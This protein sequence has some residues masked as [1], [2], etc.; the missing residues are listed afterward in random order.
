MQILAFV[1]YYPPH[2]G[3]LESY[4]HQVYASLAKAHGVTVITCHLDNAPM[5]AVLDGV[6]VVRVPCWHLLRKTF[7][8]PK[9]SQLLRLTLRQF[10][11][12][13]PD[14]IHTHTRF[15]PLS[16]I[17]AHLARRLQR[18]YVHVE[19]GSAH[20]SHANPFIRWV[21]RLFDYCFGRSVIRHATT[22]VAVS[23][24]AATFVRSFGAHRV[25]VIPNFVDAAV[26]TSTMSRNRPHESGQQP[27]TFAYV[28]R[29]I[30]MKGILDLINV[31]S[32]THF[33]SPA[34]LFI[35]GAGSLESTVRIRA[36]VD[37]RIQ[38]LGEKTASEIARLLATTDVIVN[39]SYNEGLPTSI[40]EG[41]LCGCDVI[42]TAVGGTP[43]IF[44]DDR[45]AFC[46]PAGDNEI[47]RTALVGRMVNTQQRQTLL[48]AVA[49]RVRVKY[50]RESAVRAF[51]SLHH[52]LCP[53]R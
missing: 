37:G 10:R 31:F 53:E 44:G 1:T 2:R 12:S 5:E 13:Q 42:A 48:R 17:G 7:P 45:G 34:Q 23:E 18:S 36:E 6:H 43:E 33:P 4:A 41:L 21:A 20:V 39:P 52:E 9:P 46:I 49:Q 25:V 26:F 47:L 8:V 29:L 3:G 16:W 22:V 14:I 50:S 15:F 35:V 38:I 30:A 32:S 19:H 28:G 27:F 51:E 11:T 24:A 40:L